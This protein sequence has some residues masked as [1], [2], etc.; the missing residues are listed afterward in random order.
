MPDDSTKEL[1]IQRILQFSTYRKVLTDGAQSES[2][3]DPL[4]P[5]IAKDLKVDE[6]D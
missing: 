1:E 3:R 6:I 2:L 5:E 4:K